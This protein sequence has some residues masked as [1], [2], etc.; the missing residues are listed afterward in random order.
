MKKTWKKLLFT[1]IRLET[2][3]NTT[4]I[5][6]KKEDMKYKTVRIF[7]LRENLLQKN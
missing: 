4:Q 1:K 6:L 3:L 2:R 7:N 5:N